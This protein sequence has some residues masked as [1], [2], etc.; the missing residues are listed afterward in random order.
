V[1]DW[2]QGLPIDEHGERAAAAVELILQCY[3]PTSVDLCHDVYRAIRPE[4]RNGLLDH[5][6]ASQRFVVTWPSLGAG[7]E[8][9]PT[10]PANSPEIP[11]TCLRRIVPRGL[12]GCAKTALLA[13]TNRAGNTV[14]IR[15]AYGRL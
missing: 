13:I 12:R 15:A 5:P 3:L 14:G 7:G 8:V 1:H 6:V 11:A 4:A 9:K 2:L 10:R